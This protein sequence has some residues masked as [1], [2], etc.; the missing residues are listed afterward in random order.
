MNGQH[1]VPFQ[2]PGSPTSRELA[3]Q[4]KQI[5]RAAA[6]SMLATQELRMT[7]QWAAHLGTQPVRGLQRRASAADLAGKMSPEEWREFNRRIARYQAALVEIA[8]RA[9]LEIA[10]ILSS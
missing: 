5:E 4:H 1:I 7:F 9:G 6:L 8:D 10:G 3:R 2:P